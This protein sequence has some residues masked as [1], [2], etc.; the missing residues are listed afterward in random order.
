MVRLARTRRC[1]SDVEVADV[2]QQTFVDARVAEV[3]Y[4]AA[5]EVVAVKERAPSGKGFAWTRLTNRVPDQPLDRRP[6]VG[7]LARTVAGRPIRRARQDELDR[8]NN[9]TP[10]RVGHPIRVPQTVR[11]AVDRRR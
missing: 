10:F 9:A 3:A 11:A 8:L 1:R 2:T 4:P 7:Q 6:V 5:T